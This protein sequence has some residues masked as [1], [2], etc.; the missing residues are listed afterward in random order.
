VS[1]EPAVLHGWS[2]FMGAGGP[3]H[4]DAVPGDHLQSAYRLW[5]AGR[6]LE[7]GAEPWLDP[8]SFRPEAEPTVNASW[9]PFG[10]PYW[11]LWRAL[12]FV[13]AW[14]AFVLLTLV[15]GGLLTYAWLRSLSLGR[16]A[17]LVG[18]LAFAIAPYRLAQSRDH[19]LAAAAILLPLALLAL[20]QARRG[21]GRWWWIASW[22][23][24]A[25]IPLSGQVHLALG[26]TAFYAFYA[27]VRIGWRPRLLA[28]AAVAIAGTVAA[29]VLIRQTVIAGSLDEGG[30]SL[31]EVAVYSASWTDFA[32]RAEHHGEERFVFLG[33][34]TPLVAVAGLVVLGRRDRRMALV[35]GLG[36]AVPIL[37]ALGTNTPLYRL[38]WHILP[39]L[40]YPRVPARL[41]P[42][43]C[44]ALAALVAY[45]VAALPA[46]GRRVGVV[47]IAGILVLV[48]ADLHVRVFRPTAPGSDRAY[49]A[50]RGSTS[51]RVLDLPVFLPDMQAGGVYLYG[52][53]RLER[54][55]PSGYSTTAPRVAD[56][57]ARALRP[58]G[59]G[60]WSREAGPLPAE[61]G[62]D[63]IVLHRALAR[64][65]AWF[66]WRGLIANGWRPAADD[67]AVAVFARGRST[68][69]PAAP[70]PPSDAAVFCAGWYPPDGHGRQ[71][72]GGYASLWAFGEGDLRLFVSAPHRIA[73][74]I[75]ADG[76]APRET[77]VV[78]RL[79]QVHVPLEGRRWHLVRFRL[80][81]VPR[82][83]G[84]A[85]GLRVVAYALP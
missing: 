40:R 68:R 9:W 46:V 77:A 78:G 30:R 37:L 51:G 56:A 47:A 28:A 5:L 59:C 75:G 29:G 39:P 64:D 70:A 19:L 33:W 81:R 21:R 76:G 15:A 4:G 26:A 66:A 41:L 82:V 17:A 80:K 36:A 83:S 72:D 25:S 85:R 79:Q 45:A 74:D 54:E 49:A 3:A 55:R 73:V 42:I 48:L 22:L 20:E 18:G 23:A 24:L 60:D 35:L 71:M 13:R 34:L 11:P 7:R 62:V 53:T 43:A 67:G 38:L 50:A 27:A 63:T 44:L 12:G 65:R 31:A 84:N 69:A 58:L 14:N 2:Q 52:T 10:L 8:Y 1:T 16:A 32:T 61:L 57:T 6:Q